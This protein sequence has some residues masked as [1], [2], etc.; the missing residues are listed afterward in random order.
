MLKVRREEEAKETPQST[1]VQRTETAEK[2]FMLCT[3]ACDDDVADEN[4]S[5]HQLLAKRS[6]L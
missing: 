5:Q 3:G 2:M 6:C 1:I 4:L